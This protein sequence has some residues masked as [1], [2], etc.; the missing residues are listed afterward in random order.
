MIVVADE[1]VDFGIVLGLRQKGSTFRYD[2]WRTY[3]AS[4]KEKSN[5]PGI[6]N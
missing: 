2:N 6:R 4:E 5:F 3:F 1:S